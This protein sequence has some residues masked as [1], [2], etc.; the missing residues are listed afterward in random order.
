MLDDTIIVDAPD[1]P[2][3]QREL[4]E[5]CGGYSPTVIVE[6]P[7]GYPLYGGH[8]HHHHGHHGIGGR[9][10]MIAQLMGISADEGL[11][12]GWKKKRKHPLHPNHPMHPRNRLRK[13]KAMSDTEEYGALDG[14]GATVPSPYNPSVGSASQGVRAPEGFDWVQ[15]GNTQVLVPNTVASQAASAS[16]PGEAERII[17]SFLTLGP[18]AYAQITGKTPPQQQVNLNSRDSGMSW[19]WLAVGGVA[20]LG[21]AYMLSRK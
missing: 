1:C 16:T 12:L 5:K 14:F 11:H 3:L 2:R 10:Q 7:F 19:T 20:L 9:P 15:Q 8:G 4:E 21:V 18:A 17:N 13:A 6:Q